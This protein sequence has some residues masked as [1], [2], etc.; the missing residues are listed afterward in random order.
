M[1]ALLEQESRRLE[2]E[3]NWSETEAAH[4]RMQR[5]DPGAWDN[6]LAELAEVTASEPDASAA[7]EW[8]EHNR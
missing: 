2:V 6:Y 8:P 3:Q 5:D 7:Q 1:S 4:S